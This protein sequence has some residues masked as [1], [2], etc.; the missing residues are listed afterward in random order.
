MNRLL[1]LSLAAALV[2]GGAAAA[3]GAGGSD[4]GAGENRAEPV[5]ASSGEPEDADPPRS[6]L[7]TFPVIVGAV[8]GVGTVAVLRRRNRVL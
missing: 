5:V 1:S 8:V 3:V 4:L 2:L 7:V 6:R